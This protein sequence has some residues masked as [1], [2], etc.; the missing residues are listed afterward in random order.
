MGIRSKTKLI[1]RLP[2]K[3]LF[4]LVNIVETIYQRIPLR[5]SDEVQD[6][7]VINSAFSLRGFLVARQAMPE[8]EIQ[9]A[10]AIIVSRHQSCKAGGPS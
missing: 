2:G 1:E 10:M 7:T 8:V 9:K 4:G 3:G 5:S 6:A